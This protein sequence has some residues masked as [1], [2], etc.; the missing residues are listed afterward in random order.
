MF[1]PL[2]YEGFPGSLRQ[3]VQAPQPGL[4]PDRSDIEVRK[5]AKEGHE[6]WDHT[7]G[8]SMGELDS[9]VAT[10]TLTT[11]TQRNRSE[12]QWRAVT[13]ND[14]REAIGVVRVAR[15]RL[16]ADQGGVRR[17]LDQQIHSSTNTEQHPVLG[18]E[19]DALAPPID[20]DPTV[21][22]IHVHGGRRQISFTRH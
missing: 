5:V 7:S 15:P 9:S 13:I 17:Q 19:L 18:E 2:S 10:T 11:R 6:L 14:H 1:Y 8:E 16:G 20:H 4:P 22:P 21:L 3:L 12:P